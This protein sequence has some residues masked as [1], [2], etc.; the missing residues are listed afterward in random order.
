MI[1]YLCFAIISVEFNF[2]CENH[3]KTMITPFSNMA[4]PIGGPIGPAILVAICN[5]PNLKAAWSGLDISVINAYV[6]DIQIPTPPIKI[7]YS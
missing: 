4:A 2:I 7:D 6:A 5:I 1:I 3:I